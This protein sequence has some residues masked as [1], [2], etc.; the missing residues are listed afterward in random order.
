MGHLMRLVV[1]VLHHLLI[2]PLRSE[3]GIGLVVVGVLEVHLSLS[4]VAMHLVGLLVMILVKR[5][6]ILLVRVRGCPSCLLL[7]HWIWIWLLRYWR[8]GRRVF[9]GGRGPLAGN[10]GVDGVGRRVHLQISGWMPVLG[11]ENGHGQKTA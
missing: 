2:S 11:S 8:R 10:G 5:G 7:L 3:L 9:V 6:V 4:G 1:C